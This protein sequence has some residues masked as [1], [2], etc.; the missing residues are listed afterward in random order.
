[1]LCTGER[2]YRAL[3][4]QEIWGD[5]L[6]SGLGSPSPSPSPAGMVIAWL[7]LGPHG[8]SQRSSGKSSVCVLQLNTTIVTVYYLLS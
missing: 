4:V 5:I 8:C 1:M 7:G 2:F 3:F 6:V